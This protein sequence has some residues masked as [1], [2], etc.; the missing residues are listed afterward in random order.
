MRAR[1]RIG[2]LGAGFVAQW[3]ARALRSVPGSTLV[4]VC[5]IDE[6]RAASLAAAFGGAHVFTSLD[7]MLGTTTLDA[8]HVLTPPH[9]HASTARRILDAGLSV[10][11]EKP[12]CLTG[13]DCRGLLEHASRRQLVLGVGHNFLFS[14]A[15]EHL[16]NIVTSGSLGT[17]DHVTIT[18]N[19]EL[20]PVRTGPYSSWM[21]RKPENIVFEIGSHSVAHMLDLVGQPDRMELKALDPVTLP[22]GQRFYR[23]WRGFGERGR[24]TIDL[25]F[26]FVPAYPEHTISV[27]GTLGLA[28]VDFECNTYMIRRHAQATHDLERY[29]AVTGY[30]RSLRSQAR[31]NM[32]EYAITKVGLSNH[33]NPF[34]A[35]IARCVQSFY[36][37]VAGGPVDPRNRAVLGAAVIE[38]CERL[39]ATAGVTTTQPAPM[40]LSANV[41][42]CQAPDALVL[43][44]TGFIGRRLVRQLLAAGKSVRLLVRSRHNIPSDILESTRLEVVE[45]TTRCRADVRR[46]ANGADCILH[47]ARANV[48]TWDDWYKH[49][50]EP[51][52]DIAEACL[53]LGTRRLIYTGTI[54]SYYT[55]KGAGTIT[56]TTPLDRKIT[57]RMYYARAKALSEELLTK[58]HREKGLAV[59]ILRPG[60]VIGAGASPCHGGIGLWNGPGVCRLWGTGTELLPLVLVEDVAAALALAI[61]APGI[62]GRSFN[63]V[64]TPLLSASDY[65]AEIERH[66]G[67]RL[68]AIKTPTWRFYLQ[69]LAKW[70][71]KL[72]VRHHDRR[73]PSYRDWES[74]TNKARFDCSEARR[75]LGWQPASTRAALISR[76][77]YGAI[78]EMFG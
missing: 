30:A 35:S 39:V 20:T 25:V 40:T 16:R 54:A 62:D 22:D 72:A 33:G 47:L 69:D 13:D 10:L 78:D 59:V 77:I 68:Q 12:M 66:T 29:E 70:L 42:T 60:I 48:K 26:A 19:K 63:L 36:A 5:D 43:G 73:K 64:D 38:Q 3:H 53:E 46:A 27:R 14:P 55:G 44:G 17:I 74:R 23:K 8:V 1:H 34:G 65:L 6:S 50:V 15:Y 7:D 31:R 45:G 49:E 51:T 76:G 67:W 4:A 41:N 58:M 37:Q 56:E 57:K 61:D 75:K 11:I 32:L 28:A 21:F 52:Q 18:W 2:L 71:V 24:T 9:C